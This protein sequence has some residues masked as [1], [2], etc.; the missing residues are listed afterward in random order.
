VRISQDRRGEAEGFLRRA[1][2]EKPSDPVM[3]YD[4]AVLATMQGRDADA[5][6]HF[7]RALGHKALAADANFNLGAAHQRAGRLEEAEGHYRRAL[8]ARP[9]F[10]EALF[11]LG[12]VQAALGKMNDAVR[13]LG[14]AVRLRP[15]HAHSHN[16]LGLALEASGNPAGAEASFRQA[17]ALE[18]G[19]AEALNNLGALLS[20]EGRV[21][22]ALSHLSRV[23][24]L[25]PAFAGAEIN[26]GAALQRA[27]RLDEALVRYR[28]AI[29]LDPGLAEAHNNL[30]TVL[31]SLGRH[32]EAAPEFERALAARPGF[33]EAHNN[34]GNTYR[35]LGRR[36]EA[37]ASFDRALSL[38][39]SFADARHNRGNLRVE[40]GDIAGGIREFEAALAI[41]GTRMTYYRSLT[42]FKRIT[43]G[44]PLLDRMTTLAGDGR[45]R[46]DT[47]WMDLHFALGKAYEDLGRHAESFGHL[48]KGNALKR[49]GVAYDEGR[50][51]AGLRRIRETFG[52]DLM[53]RLADAGYRDAAPVFIVGMPRSGTSL[54]EQILASHPSVHGAGELMEFQNAVYGCLG[55]PE[56][57][58]AASLSERPGALREVGE[59]YAAA[60]SR[61]GCGRPV[62]VDKQPLN[63][64]Y[65]GLI[66][67]ALPNARILHARR[68]AVD[69]CIS[70]FSKLFTA[71]ID[72]C[73]DLGE[74]GRYYRGY[75]ATMEHWR[76]VLPE[77]AVKDV[78]YEDLVGDFL[79][80]AREIVGHCGLPWDDVCATFWKTERSV[81]TAS[82]AQVRT[83][84]FTTSVGRS[85][86]LGGLLGPLLGALRSDGE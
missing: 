79:P 6:P 80:R 11:N 2:A 31:A 12:M 77:G 64:R 73:Y 84:L 66:R 35:E 56:D 55:P 74:L 22:E 9:S 70:C 16:S 19:H 29:E 71:G 65:V 60:V 3:N 23:A 13:S 28:R 24:A 30:G 76:K 62:V 86:H 53:R 43:E 78:V 85:R 63:F 17:L 50:V 20:E 69:T 37:L 27:G 36:E 25:R 57:L 1:L 83:P 32:G 61:I 8:K 14:E 49:K 39:P 44:D 82:A 42:N 48:I 7:E 41:D 18:P 68:D 54:I 33:A 75:E 15:G 52:V 59:R 4:M 40:L 45:S 38:N 34:L 10:P 51:L 47:E 72:F 46:S 5:V 58:T 21:D 26:W 67:L 81:R